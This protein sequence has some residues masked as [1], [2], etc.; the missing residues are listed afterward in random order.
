MPVEGHI[1]TGQ[2]SFWRY[3]TQPIR[4]SMARAFHEQ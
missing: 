4:D 2:R 3:M 1:Q